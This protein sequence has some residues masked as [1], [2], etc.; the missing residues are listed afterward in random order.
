MLLSSLLNEAWVS[1]SASRMRTF[2]AMLGI[3]IGVGS[4]VLMVAI[5]TGSSRQ[6][7]KAIRQLGTNLLIITP[8][9]QSA[10]GVQKQGFSKFEI[11]DAAILGQLPSV[12]YAAAMTDYRAFQ[13]RSSF[14]NWSANA[15]GTTEDG[16]RI[17]KWEFATGSGYTKEDI[18]HGE[19]VVVLGATV[20]DKLF[21]KQSAIGMNIQINKS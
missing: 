1:I 17:S 12:A 11:R 19:R 21:G 4:V 10:K 7:E 15:V 6:V 18:K 5:G 13:V 9:S 8:G 14:A 20:A 2:L 16:I 3:V